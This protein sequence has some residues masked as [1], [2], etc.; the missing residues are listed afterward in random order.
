MKEHSPRASRP[1][2]E[3]LLSRRSLLRLAIARALT[4]T[5][6]FSLA[7]EAIVRPKDIEIFGDEIRERQRLAPW[8]ELQPPQREEAIGA[9]VDAVGGF[10]RSAEG[11]KILN[12]G[13]DEQLFEFFKMLPHFLPEH[14]TDT[15][16][17]IKKE[18]WPSVLIET[19]SYH[20]GRAVIHTIDTPNLGR[21]ASRTGYGN[22]FYMDEETIITN[23]HVGDGIINNAADEV[24]SL[25]DPFTMEDVTAE[26]DR[27][28]RGSGEEGIDVMAFK[29][30]PRRFSAHWNPYSFAHN[31][32]N[33]DVEGKLVTLAGIDFD[34]SAEADGAKLCPS[35]AIRVTPHLARFLARY[36]K[37]VSVGP[38]LLNSF[39]YIKPPGQARE[40]DSS[41]ESGSRIIDEILG[42]KPQKD[43]RYSQG[44]SASPIVM[45]KKIVG[46]NHAGSILKYKDHIWDVGF[47][48][49]PEETQKIFDLGM[50]FDT[51]HAQTV[52]SELRTLAEK[53]GNT[54]VVYKNN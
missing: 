14:I 27:I 41:S 51:E 49:G 38:L 17:E 47:F 40:R 48:H 42:I 50:V 30:P 19:G 29:I 20:D 22:A 5:A 39:I 43:I 46:I 37:K 16:Y 24:R 2:K 54:S 15:K 4:G 31:L 3:K 26:E 36:C 52:I 9:A 44:T 11:K 7:A 18:N 1:G 35:I 12:E 34:E 53:K 13:T 21:I 8:G 23:V 33:E 28:M 10:I 32:S 45:D 6:V 25:R